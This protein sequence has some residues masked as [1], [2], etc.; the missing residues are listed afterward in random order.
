MASSKVTYKIEKRWVVRDSNYKEVK[1]FHDE[2][3]AV[4]LAATLNEVAEENFNN[5]I[6]KQKAEATAEA[7]R[8]KQR[9]TVGVDNF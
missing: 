7:I 3:S 2:S 6:E 4:A 9:T 8:D 1:T 5:G